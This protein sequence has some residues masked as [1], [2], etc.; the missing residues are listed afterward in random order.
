MQIVQVLRVQD[1][2]VEAR[3]G[4]RIDDVDE[5][6]TQ[7]G[8]ATRFPVDAAPSKK[9]A[10]EFP[11]ALEPADAFRLAVCQLAQDCLGLVVESTLVR[12]EFLLA[13]PA[14]SPGRGF[15]SPG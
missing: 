15:F 1:C 13:R 14:G 10:A 11:I 7:I 8:D 6:L 12:D 5:I 2:R 4:S 9:P 3:Q